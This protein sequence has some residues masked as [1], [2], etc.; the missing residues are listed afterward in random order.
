M[1]QFLVYFGL[2]IFY[3]AA[4]GATKY[5]DTYSFKYVN[6][7]EKW[8]ESVALAQD[9]PALAAQLLEIEANSELTFDGEACPAL[10]SDHSQIIR[11]KLESIIG[12]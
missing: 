11:S 2:F 12:S 10:R 7:S 9:Q 4:I 3:A 8:D 6:C 5:L 1:K